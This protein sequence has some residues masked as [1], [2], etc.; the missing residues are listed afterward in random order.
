MFKLKHELITV[1][2]VT[3]RDVTC[4][5]TNYKTRKDKVFKLIN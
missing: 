4:Y 2:S 5:E 3:K 1:A